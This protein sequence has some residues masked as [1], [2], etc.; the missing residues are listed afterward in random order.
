MDGPPWATNS[1]SVPLGARVAACLRTESSRTVKSAGA[2]KFYNVQAA[3]GHKF[4]N[5]QAVGGH[6]FQPLQSGPHTELGRIATS[7]F[8]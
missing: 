2:H 7:H 8:G 3:G 6:K 4:Q 5:V 1:K